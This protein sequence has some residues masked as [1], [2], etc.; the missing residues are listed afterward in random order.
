MGRREGGEV[1]DDGEVGEVEEEQREGRRGRGERG[2]AGRSRQ[3][4]G[5]GG[6]R[7]WK[8]TWKESEDT[9][10]KYHEEIF[11]LCILGLSLNQIKH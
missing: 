10:F 7:A 3:Q 6:R 5:R 9:K 4:R 11:M 1:A 2:G 8:T